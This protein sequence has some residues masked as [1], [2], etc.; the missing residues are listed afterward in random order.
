[1]V[2]QRLIAPINEKLGIS[3]LFGSGE[4]V[5][6]NLIVSLGGWEEGSLTEDVEFSVRL[7]TLLW[8]IVWMSSLEK[9]V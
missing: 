6:K 4:A 9:L 1:M 5:R 2:Y 8:G 3:L 7:W